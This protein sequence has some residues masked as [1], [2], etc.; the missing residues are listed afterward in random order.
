M[1]LREDF[2]LA[3]FNRYSVYIE[4]K[5]CILPEMVRCIEIAQAEVAERALK[6]SQSLFI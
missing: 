2:L 6:S 3:N 5:N 1:A 4:R